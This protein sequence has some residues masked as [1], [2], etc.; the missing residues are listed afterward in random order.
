MG[1]KAP[2]LPLP[3]KELGAEEVQ[4]WA[5]PSAEVAKLASS[6]TDWGL[7]FPLRSFLSWGVLEKVTLPS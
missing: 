3:P 1:I 2:W 4:P 5:V 6:Q 7:E